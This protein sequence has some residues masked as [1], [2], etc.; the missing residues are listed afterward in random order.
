M[1]GKNAIDKIRNLHMLV[2]LDVL[3]LHSNKIARIEGLENLRELRV[4]NL[5]NN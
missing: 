4:L 2:K 5:A 1:L 3:D